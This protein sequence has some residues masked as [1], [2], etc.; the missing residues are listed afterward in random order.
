MAFAQENVLGTTLAG[1]TTDLVTLSTDMTQDLQGILD[2][3]NN[4]Y[5]LDDKSLYFGNDKDFNI[6][7]SEDN[8]AIQFADEL[9]ESLFEINKDGSLNLH[10]T[11]SEI[12]TING[13]ITYRSDGVYVKI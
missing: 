5:V 7:L 4:V 6:S 8:N 10:V 11:S 9:T 2:S 1:F 13:N 12:N 3:Q